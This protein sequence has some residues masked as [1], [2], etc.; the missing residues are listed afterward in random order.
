MLLSLMSPVGLGLA[1]NFGLLLLFALPWGVAFYR[2]RSA[3]GRA[4]SLLLSVLVGVIATVAVAT[5]ILVLLL[6]PVSLVDTPSS[7]AYYAR[8]ADLMQMLSWVAFAGS[9]S[10][11][12]CGVLILRRHEQCS[13]PWRLTFVAFT[14]PTASSLVIL[15]VAL[16]ARR[17]EYGLWSRGIKIEAPWVWLSLELVILY[18]LLI[19]TMVL[20]I[21]SCVH[22]I[23]R[24]PHIRA[25]CEQWID[26]VLENLAYISWSQMPFS[27]TMLSR[28]PARW[29]QEWHDST[30]E[31]SERQP[32]EDEP[33]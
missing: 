13:S 28:P 30:A 5:L 29:L 12:A 16:N 22:T 23:R 20:T 24:T 6:P 2:M 25:R 11:L 21:V 7:T 33:V 1:V 3:F 4:A 15:S 31:P 26:D 8:I 10:A 9:I 32:D 17:N 27:A 14:A 18:L 19:V